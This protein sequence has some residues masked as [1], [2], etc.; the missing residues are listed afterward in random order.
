MGLVGHKKLESVEEN[1]KSNRIRERKC[2]IHSNCTVK[3]PVQ[4]FLIS[5]CEGDV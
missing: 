2:F 4:T 1:E 5:R 3:A